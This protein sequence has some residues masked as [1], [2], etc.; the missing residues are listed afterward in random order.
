MRKYG[1]NWEGKWKQQCCPSRKDWEGAMALKTLKVSL[2]PWWRYRDLA[3]GMLKVKRDQECVTGQCRGAPWQEF[4]SLKVLR[5]GLDTP[6]V[7]PGAAGK[8]M[9]EAGSGK[10]C[11]SLC[12]A[13]SE[14]PA[15]PNPY[16]KFALGAGGAWG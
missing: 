1:K 4:Q 8:E 7:L 15:G 14:F 3:K 12:R 10:W 5:A 9:S 16:W 2:S 6:L 13:N 11:L